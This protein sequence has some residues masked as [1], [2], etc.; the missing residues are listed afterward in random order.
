PHVRARGRSDIWD[1]D[2]TNADAV[3]T[4]FRHYDNAFVMRG[5]LGGMPKTAWVMDYPIFERMYYDLVAGFD[6][7]GNLAHQLATRTYMNLLRIESEGQFLRLLPVSERARVHDAWYR[8]RVARALSSIHAQA[9]AGPEPIDSFSD[10]AHAKEEAIEALLRQLAPVAGPREPIQWPDVALSNEPARA[11][12]EALMRPLVNKPGAYV[13]AFPDT[14]LVQLKSTSGQDLVYTIA[15]NRSHKSVEFIFLEGVEL[16]PQ[17][18]TL[19]IVSGI[20]TSRP[21]LFLRVNEAQL[22][23]FAAALGA[24]APGAA[25]QDFVAKYAVRRSDPSFWETFDFFADAFPRLDP[26][27]AAVLDLSRYSND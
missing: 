11:R 9:F 5:A 8:G 10:R 12:F 4:V 3:L 17:E 6:V 21:N 7:Y 15:R 22:D 14:L 2:G 19:Q 16:E 25:W 20:V 13:D 27:G 1:G 23:E 18:D 26:I 24:L